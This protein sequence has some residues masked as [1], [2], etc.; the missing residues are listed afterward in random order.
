MLHSF[1]LLGIRF[2][3][4]INAVNAMHIGSYGVVSIFYK[5]LED[6]GTINIMYLHL[7]TVYA[8]SSWIVKAWTEAALYGGHNAKCANLWPA[9]A[10]TQQQNNMI[11]YMYIHYIWSSVHVEHLITFECLW[12]KDHTYS[13]AW[14]GYNYYSPANYLVV[15]RPPTHLRRA[16]VKQLISGAKWISSVTV[17]LG[18]KWWLEG[19]QFGHGM[20]IG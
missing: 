10:A 14:K 1:L 13:F 5:L 9:E 17:L 7:R 4:Y 20:V 19:G 6:S 2:L 18:W 3:L 16:H 12:H 15:N 8:M 11:P